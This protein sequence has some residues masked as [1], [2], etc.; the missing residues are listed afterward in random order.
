M[1]YL[2]FV[3]WLLDILNCMISMRTVYKWAVNDFMKPEALLNVDRILGVGVS[4]GSLSTLVVTLIYAHRI[5]KFGGTSTIIR[6]IT[7]LIIV[8]AAVAMAGG[9][10]IGVM[11]F[12]T[13][14]YGLW[15]EKYMWLWDATLGTR[16]LVDFLIA[17]TTCTM[18]YRRRHHATRTRSVIGLVILYTVNTCVL[19]TFCNLMVIVTDAVLPSTSISFS[20]SSF[21]PHLMVNSLL[22]TLNSRSKMRHMVDGANMQLIILSSATLSQRTSERAEDAVDM[23]GADSSTADP[24]QAAYATEHL[25]E[26]IP[27]VDEAIPLSRKVSGYR[28]D[29]P[30][31]TTL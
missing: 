3:L 13:E 6:T 22:A 24:Q 11:S 31:K 27:L 25:D 19:S 18:L 23:G 30:T 29:G 9:T 10:G 7:G 1:K 15:N 2:V 28:T 8:G 5:W 14:T 4:V 26:Y 12:K 16:V 17:S 21:T 20:F